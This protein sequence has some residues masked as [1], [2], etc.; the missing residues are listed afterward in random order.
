M[1]VFQTL[2][3]EKVVWLWI[4]LVMSTGA[5]DV[6]G[7][8]SRYVQGLTGSCQHWSI[9]ALQD[10]ERCCHSFGVA[11]SLIHMGLMVSQIS[12]LLTVVSSLLSKGQFRYKSWQPKVWFGICL[13]SSNT[14]SGTGESASWEQLVYK[15]QRKGAPWTFPYAMVVLSVHNLQVIVIWV[16]CKGMATPAFLGFTAQQSGTLYCSCP[17]QTNSTWFWSLCWL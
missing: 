14:L 2:I 17:P 13:L 7:H 3:L 8:G 1:S 5:C 11:L 10:N 12:Q 9:V 4:N 16:E 6:L 15:S